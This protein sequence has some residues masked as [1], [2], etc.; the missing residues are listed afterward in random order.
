MK[1]NWARSLGAS[2]LL[3]LIASGSGCALGGGIDLP[4]SKSNEAGDPSNDFDSTASEGAATTGGWD[5][6]GDQGPFDSPG[7][8]AGG[9]PAQTC[10]N[11]ETGSGGVGSGGVGSGGAGPSNSGA[12][13][14]LTTTGGTNSGGSS[15]AGGGTAQEYCN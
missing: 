13:G 8:A 1:K 5:T 2:L 9:A 7:M 3:V 6:T 4:S 10:I 14:S 12:G 15:A 11:Q